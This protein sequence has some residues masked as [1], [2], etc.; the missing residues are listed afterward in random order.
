LN[1]GAGD[2]RDDFLVR[3]GEN[4]VAPASVLEAGHRVVDLVPPSCR[5]PQLRRMHDRQAD[6]LAADGVQ[7]FAEDPGDLEK[8]SLGQREVGE[9]AGR[10]LAHVAGAHQELVRGDLRVARRLPERRSEQ[11][12]DPHA[13]TSSYM[14]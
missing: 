6:L 9:D 10:E 4:H 3:H 5:L 8:R 1:L 12:G 7:L 14:M 2:L 11:V 13:Q